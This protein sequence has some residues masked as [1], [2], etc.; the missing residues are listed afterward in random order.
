[1]ITAMALRTL[2]GRVVLEAGTVV[3]MVQYGEEDDPA[4]DNEP[5]I[6]CFGCPPDRCQPP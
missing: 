2:T 3:G 5:A 4:A 6:R 1:M